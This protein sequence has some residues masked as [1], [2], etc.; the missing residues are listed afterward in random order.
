MTSAARP[1]PPPELLEA[2]GASSIQF[3]SVSLQSALLQGHNVHAL[4]KR[5]VIILWPLCIHYIAVDTDT[6]SKQFKNLY[7]LFLNSVTILDI[8]PIPIHL[9]YF[10]IF[11]P[12]SFCPLVLY[13][14]WVSHRSLVSCD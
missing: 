1:L 6:I 7:T 10:F 14:L 3:D 12:A 11:H 2:R 4:W 5:R 8:V 13:N 9:L